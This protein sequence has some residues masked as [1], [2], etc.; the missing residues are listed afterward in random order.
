MKTAL[1]A[2]LALLVLAPAAQAAPPSCLSGTASGV[3]AGQ[4]ITFGPPPCTDPES[5][6]LTYTVL[7]G[8]TH[9]STQTSPDLDTYTAGL[10]Y[11]GPDPI[12]YKATDTDTQ[13]SNVATHTINV[14][15][16]APQCGAPVLVAVRQILQ[17]LPQCRD[18]EGEPFTVTVTQPP[19][20]GTFDPVN[21][22][23]TSVPG[24]SGQDTFSY[25]ASDGHSTSSVTTATIFVQ[26]AS[27]Q[28]QLPPPVAGKTVNVEPTGT[29]RVRVPGTNSYRVLR[30][31]EQ[32]KVGTVIDATQGRITLTASVGAAARDRRLLRRRVQHL[33]DARRH[34]AAPRRRARL[35]AGAGG[36]RHEEEAQLAV[37]PREGQLPHPRALRLGRGAR[38]EVAHPRPVRRD[39]LQGRD[40]R[41]RGPGLRARPDDR[42][43]SGRAYLAKKRR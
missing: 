36:G 22:R 5:Q 2:L 26:P 4:S 23:Y 27:N 1:A 38:D 31:D 41:G 8:P 34:R 20:H 33:A 9:G 39:V 16:S 32:L 6:T 42:A 21:W 17:M 43:P 25:Q 12:T 24:Y 7:S 14:F 13:D 11:T 15:D 40:G 3:Q 37:G 19:A 29:V 35:Q 30:A 10:G 28:S 18:P